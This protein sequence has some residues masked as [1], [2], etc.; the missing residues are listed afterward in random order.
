MR[1]LDR[2]GGDDTADSVVDHA[3]V[4]SAGRRAPRHHPVVFYDRDEELY[5]TVAARMLA[6]PLDAGDTAVVV[7]TPTH[8][9]G[10]DRALRAAGIDLDQVRAAGRYVELD[11]AELLDALL[12]GGQPDAAYL[13]QVVAELVALAAQR[14]GRLHVF[15]EM[16]TLL[17]DADMAVAALQLEAV[18][19]DLLAHHD[20]G[21]I[22]AYSLR[23]FPDGP[24]TS[25]FVE[26]CASHSELLGQVDGLAT[27]ATTD[28]AD[29]ALRDLVWEQLG[30]RDQMLD[31]VDAAV[32]ATD[33]A[34]T[35]QVWNAGA[36]VLH[37]WTAREAIGRSIFELTLPVDQQ[38]PGRDAWASIVAAGGW[39]GNLEGVRPDGTRFPAHVRNEVIRD[40]DGRPVGVVGVAVDLTAQVERERAMVRRSD[41]LRGL[42]DLMGEGLATL[43]PHGRII[44]VNPHGERLLAAPDARSVGGSFVNRLLPVR[45]DGTVAVPSERLI[46][47]EFDGHLPAELTEAHLLH[48][49]GSTVPIEY[50]ATELPPDEDGRPN[51][52]VVVFRDVSERVERERKLRADANHAHWMGRIQDALDHDRFVLHAQPIVDLRTG[53]VVQHE[54]LIRLED[55]D[56]GLISPGAFLPTAEAYGLAPVI[57]RWVVGQA[58]DLAAEGQPVEVNLSARSF[59]DPTLPYLVQQL[60]EETGADPTL[61]VFELTET[62][63]LDNEQEAARFAERIRALGCQLALDDFGTGYGAFIHLKHLPVNLLKVDMEFVRD[64]LTNPASRHVICAVVTLARSLGIRTVAEGVEDQPTLEL[65]AELGVDQAQGFHL[66][67]PVPV[68]LH[69]R[70]T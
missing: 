21:L 9:A 38:E 18:G 52:W 69:P 45:P 44:S 7:A 11:A 5:E 60:L 27:P 1:T 22:C 59:S 66:G 65:L 14:N 55:P 49:D 40:G 2:P 67:R 33:L 50:V 13:E 3:H 19:N 15:S 48:A 30:I 39:E 35:V 16:V 57:D 28:A 24:A 4:T 43:D 68:M 42:T 29:L 20:F 70:R 47:A 6:G 8:R 61:L 37:G 32:V 17:W 41:W 51:G 12:R 34:G 23:A 46:G 58:V 25:G 64:A 10:F 31:V 53:A 54:L 26:V 63:M 36:R 56:E 62:A